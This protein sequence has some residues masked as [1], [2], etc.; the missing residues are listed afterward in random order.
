MLRERTRKRLASEIPEKVKATQ[1]RE[2]D[3]SETKALIFRRLRWTDLEY[4]IGAIT[5][6]GMLGARVHISPPSE[7][8]LAAQKVTL[9][10]PFVTVFD[11]V[12][13]VDAIAG[14]TKENV[15][16]ALVAENVVITSVPEPPATVVCQVCVPDIAPPLAVEVLVIGYVPGPAALAPNP[17][18]NF[19]A[20]LPD[21]ENNDKGAGPTST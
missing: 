7:T 19:E 4:R 8:Q 18:P 12:A 11:A 3:A 14:A 10:V 16:D 1:Q 20:S 21:T 9:K 5:F 6:L 2:K 13:P 15:P 17:T